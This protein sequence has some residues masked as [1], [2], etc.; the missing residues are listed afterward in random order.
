MKNWLVSAHRAPPLP[1]PKPAK[2]RQP[3]GLGHF[4]NNGHHHPQQQQQQQSTYHQQTAHLATS[5]PIHSPVQAGGGTIG[6]VHYP[7]QYNHPPLSS[8][9]PVGPSPHQ[10]GLPLVNGFTTYAPNPNVSSFSH[11]FFQNLFCWFC[12]RPFSGDPQSLFAYEI[13]FYS[14]VA[15]WNSS[16]VFQ[17]RI[18]KPLTRQ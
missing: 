3:N 6:G 9:S 5:G 15:H 18:I 12:I 10:I 7:P 11:F 14:L 8:S 2:M 13:C 17:K 4:G 1:G 16:D